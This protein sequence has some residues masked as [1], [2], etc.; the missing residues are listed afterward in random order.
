MRLNSSPR[1]S[2]QAGRRLWVLGLLALLML[3][4]QQGAW[5]HGLVHVGSGM[6]HGVARQALADEGNAFSRAKKV[7][8]Q[9]TELCL[10]CLAYAATAD[11]MSSSHQPLAL[12]EVLQAALPV[13]GRAQCAALVEAGYRS[14]A[15]PSA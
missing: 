3:L 10:E 2:S 12:V 11:A 4:A 14:R 13:G 15:P 6:G 9:S 5:R 7:T 8:D 1:S